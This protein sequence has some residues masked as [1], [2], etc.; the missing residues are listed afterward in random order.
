M[1]VTSNAVEALKKMIPAEDL[2]DGSIRFFMSAG[3]CGPSLQ[4]GLIKEEA[5]NDS[6]FE[7]DGIRFSVDPEAVAQVEKVTLDADNNGF[8]LDG[9]NAP[10]CETT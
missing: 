9:Y 3:C 8:R 6:T 4:M 7:V 1:N 10:S 2:A 5:A